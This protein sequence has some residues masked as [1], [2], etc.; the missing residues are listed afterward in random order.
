M[1]LPSSLAED[2]NQDGAA[3]IVTA[4]AGSDAVS[5][6][7]G[8]GL[9]A[10]APRAAYA[11]GWWTASV[12]VGQLSSDSRPDL[13]T[14]NY[15]AGTIS[16]LEGTST[17]TFEKVN[18]FVVTDRVTSIR[19][20]DLNDD[21]LDDLVAVAHEQ[22]EVVVMIRTGNDVNGH[23]TFA[24]PVSYASGI[25]PHGLIVAD[26]NRDGEM[27]L[28]T[29]NITS[30]NATYFQGL[31]DGTFAAGVF[32]DVGDGAYNLN[33]GDL[34]GDGILDVAVAAYYANTM[35]FLLGN[36]DGTFSLSPLALAMDAGPS[37]PTLGNFDGNGT[38][39]VAGTSYLG[40]T[41][42]VWLNEAAPA[43]Q[44][45]SIIVPASATVGTP[46]NVTVT[47]LDSDDNVAIS[48][49]G[50]VHFASSDRFANLPPD[51]TFTAS[52]AGTKTFTVTLDTGGSQ[53]V[54]A[55]LVGSPGVVA[56]ALLDVA[57]PT[58][59]FAPHVDYDQ[60]SL[61]VVNADFN[62]DGILDL[63]MANAN[64][65]SVDVRF[66]TGDGQF[67]PRTSVTVGGFPYALKAEKFDS[68]DNFDLAVVNYTGQQLAVLRG[69][70][71]GTFQSP[72]YYAMTNPTGVDVGDLNNDD[73]L[74]IVV[75]DF[76]NPTGALR[77]LLGNGDA[78]FQSPLSFTL[79]G[80][81]LRSALGDFNGDHNLDV[82][83]ANYYGNSMS[84]LLG[85][86]AGG[87]ALAASY[88][89]GSN[90][91][92]TAVD[93][94]RDGLLD[95]VV[96]DSAEQSGGSGGGLNAFRNLGN[97]TFADA[98]SLPTSAQ[99]IGVTAAE[100]NGDGILDL[101]ATTRIQVDQVSVWLGNGD[102]TFESR[103]NFATATFPYEL[104][105]ADLNGNG[106]ID[107][108]VSGGFDLN[109]LLNLAAPANPHLSM[110]L[111]ASATLGATSNITVTA[112]DGDNNVATGFTGTVHFASS[113]RFANL[114]PD[115]IFT[116]GDAST[117][118]FTVT[119]GTAG[120]QTV[121]A[122]LIGS[123]GIVTGGVI[124]VGLSPLNVA[125]TLDAIND[126]PAILEDAGLQIVNLTGISAG[127]D[128]SQSLSITATSSDPDL[129]PS[130]TVTYGS[131]NA[132]GSLS[133]TPVAN[134]SGS[135]TITVTVQ[136]NGGTA[137]GGVDTISRTFTVNITPVN[138][139]PSFAVGGNVAVTAALG[140]YSASQASGIGDGDPEVVQT[141]MFNVSNSD[142][143]LFAVQP[144]L[145]AAG[146]LAFT[147]AANANGSA[148][149]SVTLIDDATAGG[150]AITTAEQTFTI[151][152]S[153]AGSIVLINDPLR[154]EWILQVI[155]TTGDDSIQ[156]KPANDP[157]AV[158]VIVNGVTQ[159]VVVR[160]S[161]QPAVA[162]FIVYGDAGND[163]IQVAGHLDM[164]G[165]PLSSV[166]VQETTISAAVPALT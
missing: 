13:V 93:L 33:A 59:S 41:L 153:S 68:D 75:T 92:D 147:P 27:D 116:A 160:G 29:A 53:T 73:K 112:L 152:V 48:F 21:G 165:V 104:T 117:R 56:G 65:G 82:V 61:E 4:D 97:G 10:F 95:V 164:L 138:D 49:I 143:S 110:S 163:V 28:M 137:N 106:T 161:S 124:N 102:F 144:A 150:A 91:A 84:V 58:V 157:D 76:I 30:N 139:A 45:L 69:N 71:D 66:G 107:V 121:S 119:P 67:G 12:A 101:I 52:D 105:A 136:D 126:P 129:I 96:A 166:A 31:G 57:V 87:L 132:T 32:I 79:G 8:D 98:L 72:T 154:G 111:P 80:A 100:V 81:P 156:V 43:H 134:K 151:T 20:I 120:I 23:S 149:V 88:P 26:F 77:V 37:S 15:Y 83:T 54:S 90:P 63:A 42:R 131:P 128:E 78:T 159:D 145:S 47:A 7:L 127:T 24:T 70:A 38:I 60:G 44:H 85:N 125:P 22:H 17:G 108:A 103:V 34:N 122:T 46:F 130:P 123:T 141:L 155:G 14:T 19:A 35:R 86:G 109:V 74:D 162:R 2:A 142:N 114:P 135:A 118:S 36:G 64:L 18:E 40:N 39:D 1:T 113:D 99:T 146:V 158:R 25:H 3:D 115:Y 62:H 11:S 94:D 133:Y 55:D 50:T 140:A 5:V 51:Y 148:T 9:G 89:A 6:F 16:V